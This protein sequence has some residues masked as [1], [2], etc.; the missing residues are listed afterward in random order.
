MTLIPPSPG[1][2]LFGAHAHKASAGALAALAALALGLSACGG[3]SS[4]RTDDAPI[5]QTGQPTGGSASQSALKSFERAVELYERS[6]GKAL[7]DVRRELES[8][9]KDDPRF[10]KA[11]FNLGF[12]QEQLG[13]RDEARRAYEK[14][15]EFAPQLGSTYVNLGHMAL[16]DGD[17]DEAWRLF[18][19]AIEVQ[20]YNAEAHNNLS[21]L[22]RQK[23]E[24]GEAVNHARRSLAGE[25]Q[26]IRPYANL[27]QIYYDRGNHEVA[28]LVMFNALQM[29]EKEPDLHN[30][31]GVVELSTNNVTGAIARFQR[32]LELAPN[33]VPA[34]MNLG[35]VMVSVRDY[36]RAIA[37]FDRVLQLQPKNTD[38]VVSKGVAVRGTGDL[39]GAR[40]IYLQAQSIDPENALVFFNLGVLE[41]EHLA[42]FAL[43]GAGKSAKSE[44][45]VDQ[46][47]FTVDNMK[48]ALV[49]YERATEHYQNFLRYDRSPDEQARRDANDRLAQLGEMIRVTRDQVASMEEQVR[50]MQASGGN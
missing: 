12:V 26:N 27:G 33:H 42:Q 32:T 24:Y 41:H 2:S 9:L 47:R 1:T 14:A 22:Y 21:I 8:S 20:P 34:M 29:D 23:K 40:N 50:Q 37:L 31:L 10:G 30:I 46:L 25:S 28:R 13:R 19:K 35:S 39:E 43:L 48:A 5:A 18:Q 17:K 36:P 44:E 7:E 6:Q 16:E 3:A 15:I 4:A 45:T 49:H 11:W 38:A